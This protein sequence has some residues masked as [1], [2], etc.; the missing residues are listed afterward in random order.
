[1]KNKNKKFIYQ[2]I[3]GGITFFVGLMTMVYG[4]LFYMEKI[5]GSFWVCI[6]L[7]TCCAVLFIISFLLTIINIKTYRNNE[8]Q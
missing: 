4:I 7:L 6:A 1:M 3:V 5:S 8:N 2:M